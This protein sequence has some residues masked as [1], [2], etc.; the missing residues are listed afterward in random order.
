MQFTPI[1]PRARLKSLVTHA[2]FGIGIY[3]SALGLRYLLR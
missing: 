2:V 3:A 1:P